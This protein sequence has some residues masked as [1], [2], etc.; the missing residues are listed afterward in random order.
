MDFGV[1]Q[2]LVAASK[3][4]ADDALRNMYKPCCD[5]TD[6]TTG[7]DLHALSPKQLAVGNGLM[8]L[9]WRFPKYKQKLGPQMIA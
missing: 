2:L 3:I 8:R 6:A 7:S 4:R 1:N 5:R 9:E